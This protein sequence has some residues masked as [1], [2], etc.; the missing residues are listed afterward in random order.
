MM[1]MRRGL[2][3]VKDET[4]LRYV[5]RY[6]EL[7]RMVDV[8]RQSGTAIPDV[9]NP[10]YGARLLSGRLGAIQRQAEE[11]YARTLRDMSQD[12]VTLEEMDEF[13]TA[14]H[15]E[16]RNRQIAS[17]NPAMPDGGSGMMSAD[18]QAI[19]ANHRATG[20]FGT[21]ERHANEWRRML[22][23]ALDL[24]LANG[25]IRQDVYDNINATY[26]YYVPLRGAP[27]QIG[28]EDFADPLDPST[29]GLSS[30]GRGM[31][32]ALG[33]RSRAQSVTAQVGS[34][35]E[36][37]LRRIE[38]NRIG[39]SFLNL[40]IAVNDNRWAEV[41]RPTRRVL[42][43]DRSSGAAPGAQVVRV[44]HDTNWASDPRNFGLYVNEP[45]AINGH[46]YQPGDLV[47]IRINNRRLYEGVNT[48]SQQLRSFERGVRYVNN[49]FRYLTTGPGNPV[50]APVNASRDIQTAFLTNAAE[51]G[52]RDSVQLVRKWA[53]AFADVF[54]QAWSGRAPQGD[55]ADFINAGG[56]QLYWRPN[57]LETKSTD[58]DA[59]YERV[60]RRDPND[61]GLA[62][63][64]LGWYPAM[65][66][67]AETATRLATYQ[68]RIAT[69]SS[70]EEAA[71]AARD[72][73]VDFA[74]G[75]LAKP[76]LNTWYM[77]LN[78]GLQGN[79]NLIRAV[80]RSVALAPGLFVMGF[81]NAAM[82]R[83]MG[84]ED[85]ERGQPYWDNLEPYQ[86][87][88][89][90][91][92]F[93][94]SGSGKRISVPLP[95]GYNV[96]YSMGVRSADAMFGR[97]TFSDAMGGIVVDSLNAFNP[98]GGSGI[99]QT[100]SIASYVLPTV[101]RP[102]A[103]IPANEKWDGSPIWLRQYD[104]FQSPDSQAPFDG[105]PAAYTA[106][107]Q[108]MNELTGGDEYESGL[109]DISPN[110]LQ[111]L[112]GYY[113]SGAGRI[114]DRA[115]ALMTQPEPVSANQVPGVRSFYGNESEASMGR[116]YYR[117]RDELAPAMRRTEAA[118]DERLPDDAR[119]AAGEGL[120]E[121]ESTM[122]QWLGGYEEQLAEIRRAFKGAS[123][124]ERRAMVKLRSQIY[125]EA[126]RRRN[127]LTD[128]FG[129]R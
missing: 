15:A 96:F 5:D 77:Y 52:F 121:F 89:S 66:E 61:R 110:T 113:L 37:G 33:R 88:S 34:V 108:K 128:A 6:D 65:F 28:D 41:V 80:S 129:G 57:D 76:I 13:L 111:Y 119:A 39:Q 47:V 46:D 4:V 17:I 30:I 79:V 29:T 118:A 14:Q 42:V 26:Q 54:M 22:R 107:A 16:E 60:Q 31:P 1:S 23:E 94:P 125:D 2:P 7:R 87:A 69:G 109:V 104:K 91:H 122:A 32:R 21:L 56:Q 86:K 20:R 10:Y 98:M 83:A 36:D 67:A 64:L 12:G 40:T 43:R 11:R 58:F 97:E 126:I 82:N 100:T 59:L 114:V 120:S 55:Y 105:T 123:P 8:A 50:F 116:A 48:A 18:A 9:R 19:L 35:F 68:Q 85:E 73:T 78:A 103:E 101:I 25:L 62:R 3:G 44:Q 92:F 49:A 63:T 51:R 106:F 115:Y 38:R 75:G 71:L 90:A 27:D 99:T 70:R 72:I 84:G 95:Y 24:R 53:P 102:A 81:L 124:E 93:D 45:M 127:E 74:K 112:V 117:M